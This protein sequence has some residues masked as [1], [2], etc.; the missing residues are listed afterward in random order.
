MTQELV[1]VEAPFHRA[2]NF[3]AAAIDTIEVFDVCAMAERRLRYEA[4]S[5]QDFCRVTRFELDVG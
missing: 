1:P 4:L 5:H 2:E 3:G